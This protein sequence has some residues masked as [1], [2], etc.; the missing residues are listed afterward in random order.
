[1]PKKR[2]GERFAPAVAFGATIRKRRTEL[3]MSQERL[4]AEAGLDRTYVGGLERG[5]RNPTLKVIWKL[6]AALALAPSTLIS[7][8]EVGH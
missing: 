4:A 1:M 6:A 5:L 7:R 3:G 8:T 2:R